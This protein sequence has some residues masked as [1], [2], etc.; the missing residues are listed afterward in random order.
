MH[1]SLGMLKLQ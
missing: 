1:A